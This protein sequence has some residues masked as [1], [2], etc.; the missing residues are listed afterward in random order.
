M[1][2]AGRKSDHAQP[3]ERG[4]MVRDGLAGKLTASIIWVGCVCD[5]SA[6]GFYRSFAM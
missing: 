3:N 5:P 1:V 4:M 6:T 2:L